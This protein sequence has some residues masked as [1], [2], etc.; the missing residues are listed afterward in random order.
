[1]TARLVVSNAAQADARDILEYL[2]G[3]AGGPTATRYALDFDAAVDRIAALPHSGSPRRQYGPDVRVVIVDPYLI[4]YE[5]DSSGG[6][7]RVLRILHGSRN[8]TVKLI[9][10]GR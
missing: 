2:R 6:D 4:F 9:L 10:K 5:A 3:E 7:V 8:I 1:M